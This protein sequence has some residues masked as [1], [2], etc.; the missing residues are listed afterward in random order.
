[1]ASVISPDL[2]QLNP[3]AEMVM[4]RGWLAV[5]A[6]V[7]VRRR[8][9]TEPD[10]RIAFYFALVGTLESALPLAWAWQ[11]PSAAGLL[12]AAAPAE[13]PKMG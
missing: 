13:R 8:W 12:G 4:P 1:M 6:K 7:T 5:I 9:R 10:I 2:R 11:T 3:L